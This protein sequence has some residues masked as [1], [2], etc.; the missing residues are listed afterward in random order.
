MSRQILVLGGTGMLGRPVV[1]CLIDN[2]HAVRILTRSAEKAHKMF[3]DAVDI[4]EGSATNRDDIRAA[5]VGCDAVHINLTPATEFAATRNVVEVADGQLE[6]ISFVSATT[7]SEENRW[8]DRVDIKLRTE[9]LLRDSGIRHA[10]FCPTWVMET[11]HNFIRGNSAIVIRG[12]NPP[13]LHF[14]AAADFGRIVAAS[15]EDDRALGKRLYVYGP[16]A[17]TLH[18]AMERFVVACHPEARVMRWKLWQ[19]RIVAKLIRNEVLAE[20]A[21]L[22][23]YIDVAGEQ[24]DPS[25]TNALYGAPAITLDEWFRM[26]MDSRQGMPH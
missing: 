19:A 5:M 13:G 23:A 25:G 16:E 21:E 1:H 26:P 4:V 17:I 7:L 15:Y 11:L 9:E 22:L 2:G 14:F 10:V 6:R 18:D 24:G 20:V 8:F 12:N 3:G